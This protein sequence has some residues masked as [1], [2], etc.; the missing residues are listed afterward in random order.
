MKV[1]EIEVHEI[2]LP[3]QDW[4]AY[5]LNHYGSP[6]RPSIAPTKSSWGRGMSTCVAIS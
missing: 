1:T 6:S 4:L 3:F 5:P 2:S